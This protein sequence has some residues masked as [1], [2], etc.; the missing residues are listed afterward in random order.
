MVRFHLPAQ[1]PY[2]TLDALEFSEKT[3]HLLGNFRSCK[4]KKEFG[5]RIE[6]LGRKIRGEG[7]TKNLNFKNTDYFV[8]GDN[9]YKEGQNGNKISRVDSY[10]S[11]HAPQEQIPKI[12]ESH[13]N[14]LMEKYLQLKPK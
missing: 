10:N 3:F 9:H 7:Q 11:R 4:T 12:S 5:E 13:C 1:K 2:H 8:V 14:E 6:N